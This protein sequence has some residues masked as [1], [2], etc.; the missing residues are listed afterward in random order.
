MAQPTLIPIFINHAH[1]TRIPVVCSFS[2]EAEY[3]GVYA[4]AR[5]ATEERRIRHN[6]QHGA[7]SAS[8]TIVLRQWMTN[9]CAIGLATE[10][11]TPKTSKSIDMRFYWLQDQVRQGHFVIKYVP[12]LQN[13]ADFFTKALPDARHKILAPY[14][15]LN[16]SDSINDL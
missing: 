1:S 8:D 10:T 7:P 4:A 11:V 14:V 15:A 6:I 13:I 3:A 2:G 12:G 9:V 16:D 5:I